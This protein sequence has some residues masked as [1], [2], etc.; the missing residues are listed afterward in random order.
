MTACQIWTGQEVLHL[1]RFSAMLRSARGLI[2]RDDH[3]ANLVLEDA[4]TE[5]GIVLGDEAAPVGGAN[6]R[7]R[8]RASP[9]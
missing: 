9:R 8:P 6:G 3:L 1:Q 5:L 7:C 2:G 4:L